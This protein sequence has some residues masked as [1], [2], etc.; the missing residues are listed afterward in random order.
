MNVLAMIISLIHHCSF[1]LNEIFVFYRV[2]IEICVAQ[3]DTKDA[4]QVKYTFT[5]IHVFV[6]ATV[7]CMWFFFAVIQGFSLPY[8]TICMPIQVNFKSKWEA[9][10]CWLCPLVE[11]HPLPSKSCLISK[12]QCSETCL[13]Q[14]HFWKIVDKNILPPIFM[15]KFGFFPIKDTQKKFLKVSLLFFEIWSILYSKFIRSFRLK[16]D[17]ISKT[18]KK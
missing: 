10:P 4:V 7:Q 6:C 11:Q 13:T 5:P 17:H 3:C 18:K 14:D 9:F 12:C 2:S 15:N 16:N 8:L 1:S